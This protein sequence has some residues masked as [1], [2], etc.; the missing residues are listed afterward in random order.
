M[1]TMLFYN[2]KGGVG[3]TSL[4][5]ITAFQL[6]RKNKKVLFVDLDA[7]ANA[8]DILSKTYEEPKPERSLYDSL[9]KGD[10]K[11]SICSLHSHLDLLP[12]DW[13]MSLWNQSVEKLDVRSRNL[14]LKTLLEPIKNNYDYIILDVSPTLSTLVNNAV[15]ASDAVTIVLQ[16]QQSAFT[17]ALKTAS[18]LQDLRNDYNANFKLT[19]IILYLMK[20]SGSVDNSIAD[21]AKKEFSDGIYANEIYSRERVKKWANNGIT[22][23]PTDPHDNATHEMYNLVI[24]EHLYRMK[25]MGIN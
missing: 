3:K 22:A 10:L 18:Y 19:G 24:K 17:G 11:P 4:S 12:S 9:M 5:T 8:T 1:A 25:E 13:S 6:V 15:L 16:T 2:F 20:K 14:I 7:Q 23:K 21:T